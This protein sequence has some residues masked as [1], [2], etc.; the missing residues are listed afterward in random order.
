[1]TKHEYIDPTFPQLMYRDALAHRPDLIALEGGTVNLR[2]VPEL[3]KVYSGSKLLNTP[4]KKFTNKGFENAD[5]ILST[6]AAQGMY[7]PSTLSGSEITLSNVTQTI[8]QWLTGSK[9]C[10]ISQTVT[11]TFKRDERYVPTSY[12]IIPAAGVP[13]NAGILR[14]TP[15]IWTLSG[16]NEKGEW[17]VLDKHDEKIN[18]WEPWRIRCF[19]IA[20]SKQKAVSSVKLEI[21]LWHPSAEPLYTGLRR[22]W[23]FGRPKNQFILPNIP[24]PSD[25]FVYVASHHP[26][27]EE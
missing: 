24:S 23:L 8:D 15:K 13:E 27:K 12:W 17:V 16:L 10:S 25:E 22:F 19:N 2:S 3:A 6:S 18:K 20:K 5:Y 14:P 9:R 26:L 1:M 21:K 11:I 7:L 4:V